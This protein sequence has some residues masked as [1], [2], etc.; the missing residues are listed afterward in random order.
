MEKVQLGDARLVDNLNAEH[1][2]RREFMR[3]SGLAVGAT[4]LTLPATGWAAARPA[5]ARDPDA[6]LARL[7]EGNK[8][9]VAGQLVHPGRRP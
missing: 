6:V 1:S 2:S 8:R 5:P 4:A 9:F 3:L 7:I